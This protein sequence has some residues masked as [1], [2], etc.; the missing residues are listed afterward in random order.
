MESSSWSVY[1]RIVQGM[2]SASWEKP[3]I[4]TPANPWTASREPL[5]IPSEP[6]PRP[7]F[8]RIELVSVMPAASR[9]I[10]AESAV[11]ESWGPMAIR[12]PFSS[13]I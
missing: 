3:L 2:A 13:W 6:E 9:T 10:L 1:R 12:L 8:F 7:S 5:R 11:E 4:G